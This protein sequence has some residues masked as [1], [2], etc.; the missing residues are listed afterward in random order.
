MASRRDRG[1]RA[2]EERRGGRGIARPRRRRG[3]RVGRGDI[4]RPR[5]T[6]SALR[7]TRH[8]VDTGSHDLE[9]IA[10]GALVVASPGVPPNAPPF[11]R[12]RAAGVDHRERVRGRAPLPAGLPYIAI[13]GTNGK[14][15]TTALA[16]HLLR[17]ARPRR[18]G[19]AGN[20]GTPVCEIALAPT[21]GV[22]GARDV[23]VPA[24]RHAERST[25]QSACSRT[26]RRTIS[27]AT[28]RGR[29]LRA[30]RCSCSATPGPYRAG[31]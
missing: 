26:S 1:H 27:T 28:R 21:A 16:G 12:A 18:C 7:G 11:A 13:T 5:R 9:R 19:E 2:R 15:T 6:A 3:V 23:V 14:T 24:A 17:C 4:G 25:R 31:C 8:D 22:G 29:V 10:R 20:I 30:T